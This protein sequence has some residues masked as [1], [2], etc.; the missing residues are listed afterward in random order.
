MI[1]I[2]QAV[3]AFVAAFFVTPPR[4]EPPY[5]REGKITEVIEPGR[6]WQVRHQATFWLARSHSSTNFCPGDLVRIVKREGLTLFIE[7]LETEE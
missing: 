4:E 1:G 7:P 2:F 5:S 6:K 3:L